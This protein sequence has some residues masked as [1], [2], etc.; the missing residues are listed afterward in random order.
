MFT[1]MFRQKKYIAFF[2]VVPL[3]LTT[4]LVRV[5]CPVCHGTGTISNTGM[6]QVEL[7]G[8]TSN[9]KSMYVVEGCFNYRIYE[10]D[11]TVTLQNNG[12]D[13]DAKGFVRL[14]LID[15]KQGKMLDDQIVVAEVPMLTR[16]ETTYSVV[17]LTLID[18]PLGARV[19]ARVLSG[20]VPDQVCGGSGSVSLN[21]W[22]FY[23]ITLDRLVAVQRMEV[24]FKL[25]DLSS[26][27]LEELIG[28]EGNT[29]QWYEE[30]G[31]TV[32]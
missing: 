14:A 30:H 11:V 8:I 31:D 18:D 27:E 9:I 23:N 29:D 7:F 24:N 3:L 20:E 2:T 5:P 13:Q 12:D 26:E 19:D 21:S 1:R 28:Q 16:I 6:G 17:F 25:R 32:Y 15:D 4:A 10:V 22:P